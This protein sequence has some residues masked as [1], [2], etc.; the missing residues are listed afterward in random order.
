[1]S[2][3]FDATGTTATATKQ[4][5]HDLEYRWDFGNPAGSPV[6]GTTW[7]TGSKAGVSSRNT[8]TGPV[9]SHVYETPGTYTVALT[10]TDGTNKVSNSCTQITVQAPDAVFAGA[11]TIC[12]GATSTPV[13][14]QDGCPAGANTVQQPSFAT[15]ISNYAKTGKRVLFKHDD[16]FTGTASASLTV[17]GPGT[18]GMYGTGAK[19][20]IQSHGG[21]NFGAPGVYTMQDWR[22]MD[23]NI[24]GQSSV[25][26]VGFSVN[27]NADQ[28]T[29]LRVDVHNTGNGLMLNGTVLEN[30]YVSGYTGTHITD[31]FSVVDSTFNTFNNA[32]GFYLFANKLVILGTVVSDT[33]TAAAGEHVVRI[34]HSAKGVIS[35]NTFSNPAPTKQTFTLR[36]VSY[37]TAGCPHAQCLANLLPLGTY[38]AL[39][40]QTIVSDNHFISG[41]SNQPVTIGPSNPD[42]W[43]VRF[44]DILFERNWYTA[45]ASSACCLAMLTIE[46][47]DVTVRNELMNLTNGA[48]HK[49]ITVKTAG[50]ASPASSNVRLYNNTIFS[51]D[52][53]DFSPVTIES[54]TTNITVRNN[55]AYSPNVSATFNSTAT[56]KSPLLAAVPPTRPA[57][58]KI[59]AG[60]YAI[61]SG[62]VVP[63]WSDFYS[64][65]QTTT[66]DLGAVMH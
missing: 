21:I 49:G 37:G 63:V 45:S 25:S 35:N 56:N 48:W 47:Q 53:G 33:T 36:G 61:G 59:T 44:R 22:I 40:S 43:D 7:K 1:M 13:Q 50:A 24:D 42:T 52:T 4:P 41:V 6:S 8:A 34:M 15:A 17:N 39:T 62:E 20:K 51:N 28:I 64:V 5:F 60:S 18:I 10:A 9:A 14:G 38:A 46:A 27:G 32:Y 19:P 54:G 58:F 31:Q 12:V 3:F 65:P 23:L 26:S 29:L 57:D 16:T 30:Q 55:L 11:N 66:R 2:V